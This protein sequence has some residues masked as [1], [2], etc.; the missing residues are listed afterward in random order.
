MSKLL[1]DNG[2]ERDLFPEEIK[3]LNKLF[4]MWKNSPTL[5]EMLPYREFIKEF[6]ISMDRV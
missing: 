1:K 5:Y 6:I 4:N 3:L 2:T